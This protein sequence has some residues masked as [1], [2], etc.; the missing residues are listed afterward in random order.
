MKKPMFSSGLFCASAVTLMLAV[1]AGVPGLS[2]QF[3][4]LSASGCG[5][6]SGAVCQTVATTTCN[7]AKICT[8][9]TDYYYYF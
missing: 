6:G 7:A 8:T 2:A 9:T 5:Q 1:V 3:D 4:H